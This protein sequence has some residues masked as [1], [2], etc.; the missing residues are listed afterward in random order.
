ML[1]TMKASDVLALLTAF[2]DRGIRYWLDGGWGVDCLLREQTRPHGDLDL[3]LPRPELDH[4]RGV[5]ESRGFDLLR[6]W[7]P[8]SIAF[9]DGGGREVDLHPIDL[10]PDGGGDQVLQDGSTFHYSPPAE[11]L[12]L[13]RSLRCAPPEDQLLMHLGYRPRPVDVADVRRIAER[14]GLPVPAPFD[15][16][17]EEP[18]GLRPA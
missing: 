16:G 13:G 4:A 12:I 6:D 3:V 11:G 17:S 18:D 15:L 10:T 2:D 8:T 5:L 14:F 7:L 9:R 1:A